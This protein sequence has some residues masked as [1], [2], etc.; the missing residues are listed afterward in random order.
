[1]ERSVPCDD[2]ENHT[3]VT[4][5]PEL[6]IEFALNL[7]FI[8]TAL[9]SCAIV[10]LPKMLDRLSQT[11][12][13]HNCTDTDCKSIARLL[14]DSGY[15]GASA[16]IVPSEVP[17]EIEIKHPITRTDQPLATWEAGTDNQS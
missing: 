2:Q 17:I 12:L 15:V 3:I 6:T 11:S 9:S 5:A 1:M 16:A 7:S 13:A 4:I 8:S 10:G 14:T